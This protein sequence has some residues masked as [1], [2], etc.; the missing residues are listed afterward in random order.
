MTLESTTHSPLTS[1]FEL[2][3]QTRTQFLA[4]LTLEQKILLEKIQSCRNDIFEF[5]YQKNV[6]HDFNTQVCDNSDED[7]NLSKSLC[8]F[9]DV[10]VDQL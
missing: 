10:D 5:A 9:N 8:D 4:T 3:E 6:L 7:I 2:G 1:A